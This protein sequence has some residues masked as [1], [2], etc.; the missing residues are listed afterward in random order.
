MPSFRTV[1]VDERRRGHGRADARRRNDAPQKNARVHQG[2]AGGVDRR[3]RG[4]SIITRHQDMDF[5]E[6][7]RARSAMSAGASAFRTAFSRSRPSCRRAPVRAP[8]LAKGA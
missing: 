7:P 5:D 6:R 1:R 8:T 3:R 2:Q 4:A